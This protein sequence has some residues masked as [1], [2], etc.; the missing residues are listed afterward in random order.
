MA[1]TEQYSRADVRRKF[2]LTEKQLKSWERQNLLAAAV[3]YTFS[4]LIAIKTLLKLR[5]NRIST[6]KIA[7]ALDSLREK[8]D[9]IKQPLSELRVLS[10]GKRITVQLGGQKMEALSGQIL[11]DFDAAEIGAVKDFPERKPAVNRTRES[12]AWFQKGLELEETGAP[13][14]QA[15]DAYRKVLELNPGAAGALVNL[16]TIYY[17][18]RRFD[19]AEKYYRR[20]IEADPGYPLAEFNLGNLY[21]EQNRTD[22]AFN[23]YRRALALNPNYADAHFNLA[24]LCER[25]GDPLK[26]VRHWKIYLKLDSSGQWADI[27]RR[28][29]ERLRQAVLR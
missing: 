27:A 24:L 4:D 21:D 3:N 7:R 14:E 11:F 13:V 20:A 1:P 15:V 17:R 12:E 18:L 22:E 2:G 29:L 23:H 25:I 16:G 5:E 6:P 19:E 8:L 9:W 26:A 28:Q 10:D